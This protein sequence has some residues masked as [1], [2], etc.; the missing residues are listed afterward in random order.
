MARS[1]LDAIICFHR[2]LNRGRNEVVEGDLSNCFGEIP[3]TELMKS[4]VRRISDGKVLGFIK[5]WLKMAVE[6]D[7][8]KGGKRRTNRAHRERKGNPQRSPISP[9]LSNLYMPRF[10]LAGRSWALPGVRGARC[11]GTVRGSRPGAA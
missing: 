3:H 9:L 4:L 8:G 2:R 10:I 1:A 11:A 6:E 5:V 7:D